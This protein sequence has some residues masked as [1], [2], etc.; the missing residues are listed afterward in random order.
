ME[1]D[2]TQ[3]G[4]DSPVSKKERL[5]NPILK[6]GEEFGH[7]RV[8][9]CISDGLLAN[10]YRMQHIRDLHELTVGVLHPRTIKDREC[11]K[12]LERLQVSLQA[13]DHQG[14]PQIQECMLIDD[15]HC[16]VMDLVQ[17]Q[18]LSAYFTEHAVP[19]KSGIHPSKVARIYAQ[20]LGL[21][22]CAH[23]EG[24]DHRD[25]DTD[26]IFIQE[27]GSIQMLG[28]GLKAAL[29][30]TVFESIVSASVS[31]LSSDKV[32][33]RL[34]SFDVMS[35]EYRRGLSE[36]YRVDVYEAGYIVY[37]LLTGCEVN[38]K[39]YEAPSS[40]SESLLVWDTVLE[41]SLQRDCDERYQSC[42]GV[43]IA[44]R[45]LEDRLGVE[46]ASLVQRQINLI[47]VPKGI[48]ARGE[49]VTR[50]YRLGMAWLV[51][52]SIV[53]WLALTFFSGDVEPEQQVV[54]AP[55]DVPGNVKINV[56]PKNASIRF[57]GIN[58]VV[59]DEAGK[60]DL[61]I[62]PG[63]YNLLVSALDHVQQEVTL[64]VAE[65]VVMPVLN[66]E[67]EAAAHTTEIQTEP[68][69]T[70]S[71][72]DEGDLEA[73]LGTADEFGRFHYKWDLSDGAGRIV[74]RK[75][76]YTP[77]IVHELSKIPM[78]VPLQ[79]QSSTLTVRSVPA[80]A[81]V[82]LNNTDIGLSPL[83]INLSQGNDQ[84][85]V[86]VQLQGYRTVTREIDLEYGKHEI[87]DFGALASCTAALDFTV[88]FEGL[89]A[90]ESLHLMA[91][92]IVEL[93]GLELPYGAD[94]FKEIP[95]GVHQVRLLHPLYVSDIRSVE[96]EDRVDQKLTY[97]MS[98]LPAQ[99]RIVLPVG[100]VA[101]LYVNQ[102][103]MRLVEG[104]L[105]VKP[106]E[107]AELEVRVENHLTMIRRFQLKP[108]ES[109]VWNVTPVPIPA[110]EP[111]ANWSVP[112]LKQKLVWLDSGEFM[113]GSPLPEVSRLPNE[114]PQLRVRFSRGFWMGMHEVTQADYYT[115]LKEGTAQTMGTH[116]PVDRVTWADA[117]YYC[118]S[119][120]K[121]ERLAGRLPDGYIYRLPTEAEWEYAARAGTETPFSFGEF[122]NPAQGNF[123]G[124]YPV[125]NK[126]ASTATGHYG[127]LPVGS[128]S[129]NGFGLHDLHGNVAEW[130]LDG[131]HSRH[132]A[133][134]SLGPRP[135]REGGLVAVRGGS[136]KD[137]ARSVRSAA[138][139]GARPTMASDAIGFRVVLAPALQ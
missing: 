19:R 67:L 112:Y 51:A 60:F 94:F 64:T 41:I 38:L 8:V 71:A 118:M 97:Q 45:S 106:N 43:L 17:G 115:L 46:S 10:Y 129:P 65:E 74:V 88:M 107:L 36:D 116:A 110:P 33:E 32:V 7:F 92:L 5:N 3:L 127:A 58:R 100:M 66:V 31:P 121:R 61:A 119:L 131:Y 82:F 80:G 83:T 85:L 101:N 63:S 35:P 84:C 18:C 42:Q 20:L 24:V 134:F 73:A 99:V 37:W 77:A 86:G 137:F 53:V 23:A 11:L 117:N 133:A 81:H 102:E 68:G 28:F 90:E 69:A 55:A 26:L 98:P 109:F 48:T 95:E 120:T 57:I 39:A 108:N 30:D 4:A 22:G 44:L 50:I 6:P 136:W 49:L 123:K 96:V 2:E 16:I 25:M 34:D 75:A 139:I 138:R 130:T 56:M 12:R 62:A 78:Q 135:R 124:S 105:L 132:A 125:H 40:M 89:K 93:N 52:I 128:Y 122:A 13:I 79:V 15:R 104:L 126:S 29:G 9:K 47:P 87:V 14:V 27:D 1:N 54:E 111:G 76:G 113:M 72:L 114:G 70:I 21:L 91:D 59:Q 103:P